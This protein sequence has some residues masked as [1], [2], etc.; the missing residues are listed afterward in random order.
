M[1][2]LDSEFVRFEGLGGFER[3]AKIPRD[4]VNG[5]A[6]LV[7]GNTVRRGRELDVHLRLHLPTVRL[8][9]T[10]WHGSALVFDPEHESNAIGP[11]QGRIDD[12]R[13]ELPSRDLPLLLDAELP[14]PAGLGEPGHLHRHLA[15]MI[16]V[17][18]EVRRSFGGE[19]AQLLMLVSLPRGPLRWTT[20]WAQTAILEDYIEPELLR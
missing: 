18:R 19:R 15:R 7:T 17:E 3:L 8:S 10:R 14:E 2:T 9:V 16:R 20:Y 13:L 6:H 5:R 12:L 11:A 4:R 1:R